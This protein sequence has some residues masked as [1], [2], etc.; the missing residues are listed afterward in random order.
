MHIC[1]VATPLGNSE[2]NVI[3]IRLLEY[4]LVCLVSFLQYLV[5]RPVFLVVIGGV[6]AVA[7][8]TITARLLGLK[9]PPKRASIAM[10][11]FS[12]KKKLMCGIFVLVNHNFDS[13]WGWFLPPL[14]GGQSTLF[15]NH[16]C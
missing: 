12:Q 9:E 7:T 4:V 11:N 14:F 16:G 1:H 15:T 5:A 2:G 8:S 3:I 10:R 6:V 13:L